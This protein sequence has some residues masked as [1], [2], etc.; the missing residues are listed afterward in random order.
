MEKL[1]AKEKRL[2]D[3]IMNG[4]DNNIGVMRKTLKTT[5][6]TLL[7]KTYPNLQRKM[8]W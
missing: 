8:G 3:Y 6:W 4:G 2:H 5:A 1:T 7:S